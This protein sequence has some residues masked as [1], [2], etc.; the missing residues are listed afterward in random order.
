MG[1]GTRPQRTGREAFL[2]RRRKPLQ[3]IVEV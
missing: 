2:V 3:I 1:L